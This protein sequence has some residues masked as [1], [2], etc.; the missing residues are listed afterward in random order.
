LDF[1]IHKYQMFIYALYLL[2]KYSALLLTFA[3]FIIHSFLSILPLQS[4]P[5]IFLLELN[6]LNFLIQKE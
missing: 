5:F 1:L 3:Q 6:L 2:S 4:Y